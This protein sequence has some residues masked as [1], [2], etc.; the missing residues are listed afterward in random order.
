MTLTEDRILELADIYAEAKVQEYHGND[1]EIAAG[2]ARKSLGD[3]IATL[4]QSACQAGAQEPV[5][6]ADFH[7]SSI[8][9]IPIGAPLYL[10][11]QQPSG[12][13]EGSLSIPFAK[14]PNC[15]DEGQY[16]NGPTEDPYAE[17]CQFCHTVPNS[18]FNLRA[19][20]A[21]SPTPTSHR[22]GMKMGNRS[23]ND[24]EQELSNCA[25]CKFSGRRFN[26]QDR[27]CRRRAPVTEKIDACL[28]IREWVPRFPIMRETDWCGE[29]TPNASSAPPVT[30][31]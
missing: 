24:A 4:I 26:Y 10:A 22:K 7:M 23:L 16:W 31:E 15:D 19:M 2:E 17:Q 8:F 29:H 13:A 18:I 12:V 14:C 28:D 11:P 25:N 1:F 5:G 6:L 20:I 30:G 3:A 21:A 27:E 9:D